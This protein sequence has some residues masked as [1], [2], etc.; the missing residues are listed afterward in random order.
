MR[1][2][3]NLTRNDRMTQNDKGPYAISR[4]SYLP[5]HVEESNQV[6]SVAISGTI[7]EIDDDLG[8]REIKKR[9]ARC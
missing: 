8:F 5:I 3:V 2:N 4:F 9:E 1:S 7:S 6:G